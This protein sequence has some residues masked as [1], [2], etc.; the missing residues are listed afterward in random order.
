[1]KGAFPGSIGLQLYSVRKD[2]EKDVPGTLARVR[3]LGIREVESA[4]LA[5]MTAEGFRKALDDADLVCRGAHMGLDRIGDGIADA[6]KEARTLGV[7]YLVCPFLPHEGEFTREGAL[8]AAETFNAAGRAAK[9][10]GIQFGYHCH[11]YEFVASTEGTLFDTLRQN[12]DSELVT[13]EIDIFWAKAGG[14]DPAALIS[15]LSGRV[16][17]LHVKDMKKGLTFERGTFKAVADANVPA[18]EGQIDLPGVVRAGVQSGVKIYFVEDETG[19]PWE[20][21]PKTLQY[22]QSLQV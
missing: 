2:L 13:F 11:G 12:T 16:P 18:G 19:A 4:G 10:E 15:S 5:G 8:R 7:R 22:L 6:L 3:S 14:A 20:K 9:A 1:V 17:L 21:I